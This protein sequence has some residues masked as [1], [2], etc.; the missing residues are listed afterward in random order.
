[1]TGE[2]L[3]ELCELMATA[4]TQV[5]EPIHDCPGDRVMYDDY[6]RMAYREGTGFREAVQTAAANWF[7]SVLRPEIDAIPAGRDAASPGDGR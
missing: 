3:R 6:Q 7:E 5:P 1:M 4:V 2:R